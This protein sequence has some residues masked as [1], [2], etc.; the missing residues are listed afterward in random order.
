MV[1]DTQADRG[2]AVPLPVEV[3]EA[4]GN[5]GEVARLYRLVGSPR[6]YPDY[7]LEIVRT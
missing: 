7:H 6:Y 4:N 2:V 1:E 3:Q 5:H